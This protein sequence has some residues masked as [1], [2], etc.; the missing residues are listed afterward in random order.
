MTGDKQGEK[1]ASETG[2]TLENQAFFEMLE[3]KKNGVKNNK[4]QADD[5]KATGRSQH[6]EEKKEERRNNK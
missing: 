5:K 1:E 2:K 3:T 6:I 4:G